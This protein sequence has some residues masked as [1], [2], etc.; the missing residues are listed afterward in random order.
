MGSLFDI[1]GEGQRFQKRYDVH[2]YVGRKPWYVVQRCI[3]KYSKMGDLILDPFMGSGVT[4]C[5]SLIK[6]RRC[7]GFDI[8]PL[9]LLITRMTCISPVNIKRFEEHFELIK[10]SGEAKIL[11]LY[12][13]NEKCPKCDSNLIL[14]NWIRKYNSGNAFCENCKKRIKIT[15]NKRDIQVVEEIEEREVLDYYPKDIPLPADSVENVK[16]VEE[17]FTKRNLMALS[18][19]FDSINKVKE[20]PFNDLFGFCF[21]A[22]LLKS[23]KLNHA[24]NDRGWIREKITKFYIP[25]DYIEFNVWEGF[26]NKVIRCLAAKKETNKLIGKYYT[27]ENIRLYNRSVL[28][29]SSLKNVLFDYILTDPPYTSDINYGELNFIQNAWLGFPLYSNEEIRIKD[30]KSFEEFEKLMVNAF[31]EMRAVL[32]PKKHISIILVDVPRQTVETIIRAAKKAEFTLEEIDPQ[33]NL[34][35]IKIKHVALHFVK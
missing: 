13:L 34:N 8:N 3:E 2:K 29:V 32:K 1:P 15:L 24:K 10:Q 6:K 27:N 5:E 4:I 25:E 30:N 21:S 31:K 14:S 22:N 33:D 11:A 17:L 23:T 9:S 19:L 35:S 20:S 26:E 16:Y 7:I 12:R 28:K 18:L